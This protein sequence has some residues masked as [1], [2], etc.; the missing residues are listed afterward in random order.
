MLQGSHR[1]SSLWAAILLS[2]IADVCSCVSATDVSVP[3]QAPLGGVLAQVGPYSVELSDLQEAMTILFGDGKRLEEHPIEDL[4]I[5]MDALI[6]AR[7]LVIEAENRGLDQ[8]AET[9]ATLDSL[10][11]LLLRDAIYQQQVYHDLPVPTEGEIEKLY[12]DWGTGSLVHGAHILLRSPEQAE[13]L[14][15]RLDENEAFEPLARSESQH[16]G[17]SGQEGSMGFLRHNQYPLQIAD[18]IWDLPTGAHTSAPLRTAMDWH[19]LKLIDRRTITQQ[20]QR[21]ALMFEMERQIRASAEK[22]FCQRLHT[23]Y[24]LT[25][26]PQTAVK[27]PPMLA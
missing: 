7:V 20:D 19:V 13:E 26:H 18:V 27:S 15:R 17:S 9:V 4:R 12:K 5:A 2:A 14:I 21:P 3:T 22:R 10:K 16:T 8:Q 6:A 25:Y 1:T 11:S 24:E 23:A